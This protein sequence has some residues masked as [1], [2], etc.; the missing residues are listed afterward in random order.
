MVLEVRLS[1]KKE[2]KVLPA[3]LEHRAAPISI[4]VALGHTSAN[5]VKATLGGGVGLVHW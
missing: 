5:E 4:S 2:F 1:S 3:P